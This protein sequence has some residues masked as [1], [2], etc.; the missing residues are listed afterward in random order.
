MS[1]ASVTAIDLVGDGFGG[2]GFGGWSGI[3]VSADGRRFWAVGDRAS[4]TRGT[5]LRENGHLVGVS[6]EPAHWIRVHGNWPALPD[7]NDLE[8]IALLPDGGLAISFEEV[9]HVARYSDLDSPA[10]RQLPAEPF[11]GLSSNLGLEALAVD[12]RGMLLTLPEV[13]PDHG[14]TFPVYTFANGQWE[15]PYA[16]ERSGIWRAVGADFGPDGR[17]YLLERAFLG[18]A[19]ISRI[20]RFDLTLPG[21]VKSG[22]V[23]YSSPPWRHDN[24]EGI[25][26]WQDDTGQMRAVMISDDNFLPVLRSQIVEVLLPG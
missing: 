11:A 3:D 20:R 17:L 21:P 9:A 22:E 15:Y 19:F 7:G 26:I 14:D 18:V 16:L 25:G 6:A 12:S 10:V 13:P 8:G 5:L 24:L 1:P 4:V 2:D 23:V